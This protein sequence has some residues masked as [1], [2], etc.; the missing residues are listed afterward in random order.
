MSERLPA[1]PAHLTAADLADARPGWT[2]AGYLELAL[3]YWRVRTRLRMLARK[4]VGPIQEYILRAV[5][6]GVDVPADIGVLLGLDGQVLDITV[7]RLL[8]EEALRLRHD[9]LQ[10]TTLGKTMAEECSRTVGE[11]RTVDLDWDGMLRQPVAQLPS[12]LEPRDLRNLG[13]RE[14]PPTPATRPDAEELRS[15]R[16]PIEQL[17]RRSAGGRADSYDLL[18]IGGI[19]RRFRVFRSAVGLAFQSTTGREV[20]VAIA[21]DGRL[22]DPHEAAFA[23]AGL[24]RR[25]GVGDRGLSAPRGS[26]RSLLEN[27]GDVS[28]HLPPQRHRELLELALTKSNRRLVLVG[29]TLRRA[30]V[31]D[32]MLELLRARLE[33]GVEIRLGYGMRG[34]DGADSDHAALKELGTLSADF[35]RLTVVRL[36]RAHP[37]VLISDR[38]MALVSGYDLLGH[39]GDATAGFSDQRGR[40]LTDGAAVDVVHQRITAIL[41]DAPSAAGTIVR[42]PRSS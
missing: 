16:D 42:L 28:E 25:F 3:P 1:D 23:R 32:A 2:L 26:I 20:Q 22:S 13:L 12:W 17:V 15:G 35:E 9:K 5:R 8:E 10:L 41:D 18:D 31:N 14:V 33:A 11:I 19:D 6:T 21:L 4:R 34:R 30:V 38:S 36:A 7:V 27:L 24:P 29:A 37:S 40:L 39:R